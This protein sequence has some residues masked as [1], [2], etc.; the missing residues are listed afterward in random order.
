MHNVLESS[1]TLAGNVRSHRSPQTKFI[2][3]SRS[4]DAIHLHH[5]FCLTLI[6][7]FL[8]SC[9]GGG[10]PSRLDRIPA[11]L[12]NPVL[13]LSGIY[14]D[15]WIGPAASLMLQQPG[16]DQVLTVRG[17]VP[18]IAD[19]AFR[20]D[21]EL[22]VDDTTVTRQ[23]VGT[24][25][26][27]L[28]ARVA[29]RAGRRRVHL[30]I[31]SL[32]QLPGEDGRKVGALLQFIGFESS[33]PG[34][35][36]SVS[37]IL[38]SSAAQLGAGWGVLETFN[39]ETF[40]WVEND[41][42]VLLAAPSEPFVELSAVVEAGPG[43]GAST[44]LLKVFDSSG[45]QVADAQAPGRSTVRMFIPVEPRKSADLRLHVDGGGKVAPNDGRILNFRVFRLTVEP[46]PGVAR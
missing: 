4:H 30:A 8:C 45:K 1:F 37:D 10:L 33:V 21:I 19:T 36:S 32:Q 44:F 25:S 15:G 12:T 34:D 13:Q 11:D 38:T 7:L 22:L 40:R 14:P 31:S 39:N 27:Q 46:R 9:S 2:M 6:F 23:S 26:F 35:A 41:A 43:V 17:M 42:H 18:K 16:G 20:T 29:G 5:C 28:S 3:R 24:G